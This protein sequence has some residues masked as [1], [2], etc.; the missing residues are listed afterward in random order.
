MF[1]GY[2]SLER[3]SKRLKN[4]AGLSLIADNKEAKIAKYRVLIVGKIMV[5]VRFFVDE[6]SI[7]TRFKILR[8]IQIEF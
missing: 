1:W 2:F 3:N 4:L 8:C 7:G 6:K 5:Q